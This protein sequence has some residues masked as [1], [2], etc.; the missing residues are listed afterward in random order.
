MKASVH[1][2]GYG[3]I[4]YNEN[5]WTG[6]RE[7]SIGENKL[8]KKKKNVYTLSGED[9]ELDCR[10]KGNFLT[11]A[12][13]YIDQDVITAIRF[14]QMVRDFLFCLN[15]LICFDMGKYSAALQVHSDRRWCDRRCNQRFR[16]CYQSVFNETNKE[17]R[18]KTFSVVWHIRCDRFDLFPD[19][20]V[21]FA[22]PLFIIF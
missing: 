12:T 15:S 18:L 3:Q 13:L 17:C 7:L 16:F 6:K 22:Y 14:L 11:G 19:R 10:I 1:H 8:V 9:G 2:I 20:R 5:F 4:E 21:Y